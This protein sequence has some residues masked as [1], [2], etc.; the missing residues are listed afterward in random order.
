MTF[1]T[2]AVL[3]MLAQ[4]HPWA[5]VAQVMH[6]ECRAGG[7]QPV[8]GQPAWQDSIVQTFATPEECL[9]VREQ[10]LRQVD[11]ATD[12]VNAQVQ[13]QSPE[14]SLRLTTT[15]VC[16]PTQGTPGEPSR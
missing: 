7:C 5:L 4:V 8:A 12:R 11:A 1:S 3:L 14:V 2:V 15:F 16:L 13:A 9:T 10:M 6:Q